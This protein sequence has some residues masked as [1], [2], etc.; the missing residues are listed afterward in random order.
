[1]TQRKNMPAG[2]S[3]RCWPSKEDDATIRADPAIPHRNDAGKMIE[4][5]P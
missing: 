4:A 5:E 3:S 2:L 1:M